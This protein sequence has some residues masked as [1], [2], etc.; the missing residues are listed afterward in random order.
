MY[1]N[2]LSLSIRYY[3]P[4]VINS[5]KLYIYLILLT[6]NNLQYKSIYAKLNICQKT[7][8]TSLIKNGPLPP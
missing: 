3:I 7:K 1:M 8:S 2:K 6:K 5:I 4:N